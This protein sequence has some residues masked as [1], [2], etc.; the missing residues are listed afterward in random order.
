MVQKHSPQSAGHNDLYQRTHLGGGRYFQR[1]LCKG[2]SVGDDFHSNTEP[3]R[4]LKV[5]EIVKRENSKGVFKIKEDAEMAYYEAT[6]V[7]PTYSEEN[8]KPLSSFG[9]M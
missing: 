2:I 7:D 3:Q 5:E 6:L 4:I 1:G 8:Y 9:R